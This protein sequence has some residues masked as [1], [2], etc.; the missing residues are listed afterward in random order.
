MSGLFFYHFVVNQQ[1]YTFCNI[2]PRM[3]FSSPVFLY[4][5][6]HLRTLLKNSQQVGAQAPALGMEPRPGHKPSQGHGLHPRARGPSPSPIR[7]DAYS[8]RIPPH[9]SLFA[10]M[11]K[12]AAPRPVRQRCGH[13]GC[14]FRE[15]KTGQVSA[16]CQAFSHEASQRSSPQSRPL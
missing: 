16:S 4:K 12:K 7:L 14:D 15:S 3:R 2:E 5:I 9:Q 8:E 1:A 13:E 10:L 6:Q 11:T